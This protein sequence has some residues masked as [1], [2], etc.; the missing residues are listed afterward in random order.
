MLEDYTRQV[1]GNHYQTHLKPYMW[2]MFVCVCA[3][4]AGTINSE[5]VPKL[6]CSAVV[7]A[8]NSGIT[9]NGNKVS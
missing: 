8:A 1:D 2:L 3:A 7:E 4:V 6:N 5:S 9:P